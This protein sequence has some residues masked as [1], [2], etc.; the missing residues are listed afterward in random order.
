M[1]TVEEKRKLGKFSIKELVRLSRQQGI[2]TDGMTKKQLISK[3]L[4]PKQTKSTRCAKR[5][6]KNKK[7][8]KTPTDTKPITDNPDTTTKPKS[9]KKKTKPKSNSK[10]ESKKKEEKE[11]EQEKLMPSRHQKRLQTK[12]SIEIAEVIDQSKKDAVLGFIR[13]I[14][15]NSNSFIPSIIAHWCLLYYHIGEYLIPS[16]KCAKEMQLDSSKTLVK[17]IKDSYAGVIYGNTIIDH[18][19]TNMLYTW[20]I[21]IIRNWTDAEYPTIASVE[22]G[23]SDKK[24][25]DPEIEDGTDVGIHY[26]LTSTGNVR[27]RMDFGLFES[28]RSYSSGWEEYGKGF[29]NGDIVKMEFNTGNRTLRYYVNDKPVSD[30]EKYAFKDVKYDIYRQEYRLTILMPHK[31]DQ[32]E[33]LGFSAKEKYGTA[34]F[35]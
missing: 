30:Y 22:I 15:P 28:E 24:Q 31:D 10:N 20:E 35:C 26:F 8:N 7:K 1:A 6:S 5:N 3:L 16:K 17:C 34:F 25:Y 29:G 33:L 23:I 32:I 14:Y 12:E 2:K 11:K 4:E 13:R 27:Y 9:P 19:K 18:T 21:M